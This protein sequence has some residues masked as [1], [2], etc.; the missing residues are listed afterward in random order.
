MPNGIDLVL[1]DHRK[2]EALFAQFKETAF[3]SYA[4]MIFDALA[5]HD[6]AENGALYP[7]ALGLLGDADLLDRAETAHST[8]KKIIDQAKFLEGVPLLAAMAMLEDAVATHVKDEET[9]L[10]P[11]LRAAATTAQLEGLAARWE[12]IKQRVG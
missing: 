7:L 9:N 5:A 3:G 12:Q 4:G 10:L 6:D 2:V 8:V 1:A 11:K